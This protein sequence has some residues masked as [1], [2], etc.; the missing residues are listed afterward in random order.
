MKDYTAVYSTDSVRGI[1]YSFM[2]ESEEKAI[3]FAKRKFS[4]YP[5]IAII[6]NIDGYSDTCG[7]LIFLN[8]HLIKG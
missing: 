3:D 5:N 6:E 1:Q 4:E 2:A 7:R 8:G